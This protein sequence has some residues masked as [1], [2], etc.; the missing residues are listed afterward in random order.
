MAAVDWPWDLA[1]VRLPNYGI[2]PDRNSRRTPF[3]DGA[4][5][6][7]KISSRSYTVRSFDLA[8]KQ[9]NYVA[10]TEWLETNANTLINFMDWHDRTVREVRVRGGNAVELRIE[11]TDE[12]LDG[13][14]YFSGNIELEGYI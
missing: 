5:A 4:I 9:S 11:S 8:V 10:F 2:A 14:L 6:Q 13:E 3:E 1:V 12:L 7:R